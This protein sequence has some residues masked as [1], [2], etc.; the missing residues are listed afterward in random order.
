MLAL[1]WLH[2]QEVEGRTLFPMND[3]RQSETLPRP[4]TD[5]MESPLAQAATVAC[6]YLEATRQAHKNQSFEVLAA[7]ALSTQTRPRAGLSTDFSAAH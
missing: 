5:A 2:S 6:A 4:S 1:A 3:D 7:L